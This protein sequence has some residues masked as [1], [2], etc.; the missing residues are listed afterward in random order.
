MPFRYS[1]SGT[2]CDPSDSFLKTR[3]FFC[4]LVDVLQM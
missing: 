2:C 1:G 4:I 3:W